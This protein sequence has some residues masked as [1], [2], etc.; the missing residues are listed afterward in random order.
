ML[1]C[2]FVN[3]DKVWGVHVVPTD[4]RFFKNHIVIDSSTFKGNVT[5]FGA[6]NSSANIT[7]NFIQN[8]GMILTGEWRDSVVAN[9][10]VLNTDFVFS[11]PG[12]YATCASNT[13]M[14]RASTVP[15]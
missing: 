12:I 8:T 1:E 5:T 15:I 7:N 6:S 10:K 9:N 4:R 2:Y 11:W 14:W 13:T 3:E